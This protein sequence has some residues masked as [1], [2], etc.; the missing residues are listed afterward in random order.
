MAK[1]TFVFDDGQDVVVPV[2]DRLTVGRAETN[3]VVVDD[4]RIS[5]Q[6]AEL[7]L[8]ADGSI[9]VFDL[10]SEAGTFVNDARVTSHTL[11][12]GDRLAFGP[13]HARLDFEL[14]P[15][16]ARVTSKTV[17]VP[18]ATT[19][20]REREADEAVRK[21]EQRLLLLDAAEKQALDAQEKW[22][23]SLEQLQK[24]HQA[25]TSELEHLSAQIEKAIAR[26]QELENDEKSR[27]SLAEAARRECAELETRAREAQKT[28]AEHEQ[29]ITDAKAEIQHLEQRQNALQSALREI[30]ETQQ[31]LTQAKTAY[32]EAEARQ[33]ALQVV[34]LRLDQ[35]R[36]S[37]E[38]NLTDLEMRIAEAESRLAIVRREVVEETQRADELRA[39]IAQLESDHAAP[40]KSLEEEIAAA[41]AELARLRGK[42]R[43]LRNWKQDMRRRA[44]RMA[45]LPP[46][47]EE[48]REL[49]AEMDT[50]IDALLE[51]VHA[52][53]NESPH[54]LIVE[55]LQLSPVPMKSESVRIQT[56]A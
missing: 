53:P 9:Q 17:R 26:L 54:T 36:E 47:S 43:P 8:N 34:L 46:G 7:I 38:K 56:Q 23:Q 2:H 5:A 52:L 21:A 6:H 1:L 39:R 10:Q 14:P 33:S 20:D 35:S 49:R 27:L 37:N 11:L 44:S 45:T 48:A 31:K 55:T 28:A 18:L 40:L 30:E 29:R 12:H 3:D 19:P 32:A 42:T 16:T 4:E 25:Q 50:E 15:E 24:D 41:E 51:L 22:R 13:L